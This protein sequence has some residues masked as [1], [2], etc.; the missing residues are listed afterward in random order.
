MVFWTLDRNLLKLKSYDKFKNN[1]LIVEEKNQEND[2]YI[3]I[4]D[5]Y[6]LPL[7]SLNVIINDEK[8]IFKTDINGKIDVELLKGISIK[9]IKVESI[10]LSSDHNIYFTTK[11]KSNVFIIKIFPKDYEKRFFNNEGYVIK[12]NKIIIDDQKYI[13]D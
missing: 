7:Q 10:D 12:N 3:Q 1:Y 11:E 4:S 5:I 13:K 6:N 8:L 2:G 9:S